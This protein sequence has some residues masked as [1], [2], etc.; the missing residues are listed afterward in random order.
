[1]S[2]APKP[3]PI[4][5]SDGANTAFTPTPMLTGTTATLSGG[6]SMAGSPMAQDNVKFVMGPN[7]QMIAIQK[8]PFVWKKFFIGSGVPVF[9]MVIPLFL[10]LYADSMSNWDDDYEYENIDFE[11]VNGTAY[12]GSFTLESSMV[13]EW[14]SVS[15]YNNSAWYECHHAS[16]DS[17]MHIHQI[18]SDVVTLVREN[19][20][21]IYSANFSLQEGQSI[22]DCD[23]E[24]RNDDAWYYCYMDRESNANEFQIYKDTWANGDYNTEQVGHWNATSGQIQ[25]DDGEDHGMDIDLRIYIEQ[26]IGQWTAATG[27]FNIDSGDQLDD[28]FRVTIETMDR[29]LYE[30]TEA[31][32]GTIDMLIGISMFM[33]CSAPIVAI[34]MIIY[35]FAATGGKPIGIGAVVALVAYP[36]IG[37]F[38]MITSMTASW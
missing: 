18:L 1:M 3:E 6:E 13:I 16:D 2:E 19:G 37:F 9:L 17:E 27:A 29:E 34:G 12:T 14:C 24:V 22:D 25:F 28:G 15:S 33:C 4:T 38:T 5:F 7:G 32:R 8:E 23:A 10:S 11:L 35:G 31:D 20:T 26:E 30:Q 21:T 36:V